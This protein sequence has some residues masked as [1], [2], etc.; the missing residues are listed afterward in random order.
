TFLKGVDD[1]I[2]VNRYTKYETHPLELLQTISH[3][4][5]RQKELLL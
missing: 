3:L 4:E 2:L 5:R 1:L